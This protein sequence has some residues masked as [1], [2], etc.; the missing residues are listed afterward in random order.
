MKCCGKIAVCIAGGLALGTALRADDIALAGNPY[1]LIVTRNIFGLNPP[2]PPVDPN[3]VP[4]EPLV[5]ITPD[6]IMSI[7]GRLQVLFKT[8]GGSKQGK[9]AADESYMLGEGQ[10][11]DDIEVV[12]IDEKAG[13]VTFNN[14]G[15]VQ[16]LALANSPASTTGASTPAAGFNPSAGGFPAAMPGGGNPGFNGGVNNFGGRSFGGGQQGGVNN[17]NTM[18]N[19]PNLPFGST[20]SGGDTVAQPNMAVLPQNAEEA[21]DQEAIIAAEHA[22]AEQEG[23]PMAKIFPPTKYDIEAGATPNIATPP[24]PGSPPIPGGPPSN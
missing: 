9:P 10:R 14:H 20:S 21:K 18:G 24:T 22:L 1:A 23:N 19:N 7:F 16:P 8:S 12:K 13:L 2:P 11:Q 6:G 15:V 17:F 5:K 4:A 3:A